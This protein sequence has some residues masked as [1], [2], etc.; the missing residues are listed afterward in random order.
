MESHGETVEPKAGLKESE[1]AAYL[2]DPA[3]A[4]PPRTDAETLKE[5]ARQIRE[6]RFSFPRND[7][8]KAPKPNL[9]N[10][11]DLPLAGNRS[12]A[13]VAER[14][15]EPDLAQRKP[16]PALDPDYLAHLAHELKTP[17]TAIAV[18]AEVM[19]D[20]RLGSMGNARYLAYASDIH[21][22]AHHALDVIASLLTESGKAE[23]TLARLI[24]LDLNAIVARTVSSV[25]ALAETHGLT[26]AFEGERSKPHVIAN[27][28]AIR[29]ILLN[30]LTN[31]IKFTP[32]GGD[33][34]VVTGYLDDGRVFLVV[35]DTGC[36][37]SGELPADSRK[38]SASAPNFSAGRGI[39]LPLV[40]RLVSEMGADLSIDSAPGK[41]TVVLI[42]FGGYASWPQ[43][44]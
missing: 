21:E 28:T 7:E 4:A 22:S 3:T 38:E 44:R 13:T 33:I 25:Q 40:R 42:S 19:C 2:L 11:R 26:L 30:L 8:P 35:R 31:A 1:A 14:K 5:I 29:Q 24:A 23:E 18:A 43:R 39:G 15:P 16:L 20:E 9:G 10:S 37:I 6:G 32:K 41:G 27:P 12:P 34:R 36:G 17:L